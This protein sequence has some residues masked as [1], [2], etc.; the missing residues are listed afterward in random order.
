MPLPQPLL[1]LEARERKLEISGRTGLPL[2]R[3]S[4]GTL[5]RSASEASNRPL[6]LDDPAVAPPDVN[7]PTQGLD[8]NGDRAA[9]NLPVLTVHDRA[10]QVNAGPRVRSRSVGRFV[11]AGDARIEAVESGSTISTRKRPSTPSVPMA[12][13]LSDCAAPVGEDITTASSSV[14]RVRIDAPGWTRLEPVRH[15]LTAARL[16]GP[17]HG[18]GASAHVLPSGRAMPVPLKYSIGNETRIN[19]PFGDHPGDRPRAPRDRTSAVYRAEPMGDHRRR[20]GPRDQLEGR[21]QR[22]T[23][24]VNDDR[25]PRVPEVE[26]EWWLVPGSA[27]KDR[28]ADRRWR[29]CSTPGAQRS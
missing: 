12:P 4:T 11:P 24:R 1:V 16:E 28:S 26:E 18:I 19:G 15:G 9:A 22:R 23:G 17:P 27:A 8:E 3:D 20:Y 25:E 29:A 7:M 10:N 5:D 14:S 6:Q 13:L 2:G 21:R